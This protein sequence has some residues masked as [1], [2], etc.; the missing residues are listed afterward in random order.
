MRQQCHVGAN[1]ADAGQF[2]ATALVPTAAGSK[3]A[4]KSYSMRF[5]GGRDPGGSVIVA[6]LAGGGG[7][8]PLDE[9]HPFSVKKASNRTT[10][11]RRMWGLLRK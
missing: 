1:P 2:D 9:P 10:G 5:Y 8:P 6:L 11:I 4:A 7:L 3:A